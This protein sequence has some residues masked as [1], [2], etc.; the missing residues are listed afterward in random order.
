MGRIARVVIPGVWHH[1]TQRGNRRQNVFFRDLDRKQYL[2]LLR[3]HC[4]HY[5]VKVTGY[6]LMTN[7]VHVIA[8]PLSETS[9]ARAF[10]RAHNNYSRWL[11]VTRGDTG[12]LWQSRYYSCPM[13]EDHQWEAL[14]YVELNPVR[15]GLVTS[16]ADWSWS[17]AAAHVGAIDAAPFLDLADWRQRWCPKDWREGLSDGLADAAPLESIRE[18]TRTR[19]PAGAEAFV[20]EMERNLGR[21]L[22]PLKRGP[23]PVIT[24]ASSQPAREIRG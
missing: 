22:R 23:K 10:G 15:A 3:R 20:R 6:C 11:N 21:R 4:A 12:H 13:D 16:A 5:G 19:R 1:V 14:R 8:V 2:D 7:H 24:V 18:A 17:S 9:L